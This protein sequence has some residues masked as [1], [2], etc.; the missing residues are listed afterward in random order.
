[1]DELVNIPALLYVSNGGTRFWSLS[2]F[3]VCTLLA[4]PSDPGKSGSF[5][6]AK[7]TEDEALADSIQA[8][9]SPRKTSR[10][11]HRATVPQTDTGRR[12]E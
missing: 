9:K 2:V 7:L 1:M 6:E 3:M 10:I 5:C 4:E 11:K 8:K 12:G